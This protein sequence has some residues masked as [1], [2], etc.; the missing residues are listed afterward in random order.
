[1]TLSFV[2]DLAGQAVRHPADAGNRAGIRFSAQALIVAQNPTRQRDPATR[3]TDPHAIARDR[4]IP[5]QDCHDGELDPLI[6]A[7]LPIVLVAGSELKLRG[8]VS[9]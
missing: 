6:A 5:V 2:L 7:P 8:K 1:M 9:V 3:D 4:Q